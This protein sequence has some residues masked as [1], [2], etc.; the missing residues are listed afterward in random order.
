V[1]DLI[2][3]H[4]AYSVY[5]D[6]FAFAHGQPYA[7]FHEKTFWRQLEERSMPEHLLLAIL[8]H[9]I[10]FSN[11]DFFHGRATSLSL[12]FA[13]VSWRLIVL[14]YFQDRAEVDLTTVKTITLL[15]LYDFTGRPFPFAGSLASPL[16][17]GI[18]Y[19]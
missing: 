6:Y 19:R 5:K 13:Q 12:L 1:D 8:S 7:F 18:S 10:R 15:S 3:S 17:V 14:L 4:V 11:H 16:Q 2:P 9:A